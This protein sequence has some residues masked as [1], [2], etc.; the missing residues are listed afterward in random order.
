MLRKI[1]KSVLLFLVFVVI[2]TSTNTIASAEKKE[3]KFF[4]GM[5]LKER[6]NKNTIRKIKKEIEKEY[7]INNIF[8]GYGFLTFDTSE[9]IITVK[10]KIGKYGKIE[11]LPNNVQSASLPWN[12]SKV[13][14]QE[15]QQ[16][17]GLTGKDQTVAV[18]DLGIDGDHSELKDKIVKNYDCYY[19]FDSNVD[20][21][22]NHKE[23][24]EKSAQGPFHMLYD[25]HGTHVSGTIVSN[26][27][28]VAKDANLLFFDVTNRGMSVGELSYRSVITA[29]E[30]IIKLLDSGEKISALNMSYQHPL[31]NDV[32]E[33]LLKTIYN[34]GTLLVAASGNPCE[35]KD[36]IG[37][38]ATSEKGT[39]Y[40]GDDTKETITYPAK[41]DFVI[42][43]GAIDKQ[44][45]RSVWENDKTHIKK[46]SGTGKELDIVAPGTD[47]MSTLP[48]EEYGTMSGTSMAAPHITGVLA[49]YKEMY[50][51][52]DTK[53]LEGML[54]EEAID[55][56][57]PGK[58]SIYGN[59]LINLSQVPKHF[60]ISEIINLDGNYKIFEFPAEATS[61]YK[62]ETLSG[63]YAIKRAK[64]WN[65]QKK[66]FEYYYIDGKGWIKSDESLNGVEK[67]RTTLSFNS[68]SLSLYNSA[69]SSDPFKTLIID[70]RRI[71]THVSEETKIVAS[72]SG[73]HIWYKINL[74]EYNIENKWICYSE[75]AGFKVV[76]ETKINLNIQL[77][78]RN[79]TF[80]DNPRTKKNPVTKYGYEPKAIASEGYKWLDSKRG[81]QWYKVSVE[82][83][84]IKDKWIE[85]NDNEGNVIFSQGL[86]DQVSS[87]ITENKDVKYADYIF[88]NSG[89]TG[90]F[91]PNSY[92]YYRFEQPV[93]VDHIYI[94]SKDI[95]SSGLTLKLYDKD[96]NKLY[97]KNIQTDN[98]EER[99]IELGETV[100]DVT[101]FKLENTSSELKTIYDFDLFGDFNNIA[102][103]PKSVNLQFKLG[104]RN[105]IFYD[106]PETKTNPTKVY[107][108]EPNVIASEGFYWMNK[109]GFKWYKVSID[110]LGIKNKWVEVNDNE[111]NYIVSQGI[112]DNYTGHIIDQKNTYSPTDL[113]DNG[114]RWAGEIRGDGY[115]TYKFDKAVSIK[116]F[117]VSESEYWKTDDSKLVIEF[118]D[119]NDEVIRENTIDKDFFFEE[120]VKLENEIY[121]VWGFKIKNTGTTTHSI[122]EIE[123]Y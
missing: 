100:S 22:G 10:K 60:S 4:Y 3:D 111:G 113:F 92:M 114:I 61:P 68:N 46:L 57:S 11:L 107:G 9:E 71:R 63:Q 95:K 28:G 24:E 58:D 78:S 21:E 55:I 36:E 93:K 7:E 121:N 120:F 118:L 16:K 44:N 97:T 54:Y 26:S 77:G 90:E 85:V 70:P 23:C 37:E 76:D 47:V 96:N 74:P 31:N 12:L 48:S 69:D 6:H 43:V 101:S 108:Y 59:G 1:V 119:Q 65:E 105:F 75:N 122:N 14:L 53:E 20:Y 84:G 49:L 38:C 116:S 27:Y 62:F 88:R 13:G 39:I 117:Y 45:K 94:D 8:E 64:G 5:I 67:G 115:L 15:V 32:E 109:V 103:E 72:D 80:Y 51:T 34:K 52:F 81:F 112:L 18:I 17:Y 30:Q 2:L 19:P 40:A 110:E 66:K 123:F 42:S 91:N 25:D 99:F 87:R 50:P 33:G 98:S 102:Y 83:L 89:G 106:D 29:Y 82:E 41:L 56:G 86:T 73:T 79:F 35:Y 104:T